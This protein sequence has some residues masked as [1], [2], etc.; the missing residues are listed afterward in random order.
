M[1]GSMSCAASAMAAVPSVIQHLPREPCKA[2]KAAKWRMLHPDF[3]G[4]GKVY[5]ACSTL[6][7]LMPRLLF[8]YVALLHIEQHKAGAHMKAWD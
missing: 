7:L 8:S 2:V 5:V 1:A 4:P 6:C 3:Q